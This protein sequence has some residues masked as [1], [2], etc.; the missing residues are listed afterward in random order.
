MHLERQALL[1]GPFEVME[2]ARERRPNR[3]DLLTGRNI[4]PFSDRTVKTD[5]VERRSSGTSA[6]RS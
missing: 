5:Q 4:T 1:R 3:F 2:E 6:P